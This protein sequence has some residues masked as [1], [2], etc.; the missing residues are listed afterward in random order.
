MIFS[1][2]VEQVNSFNRNGFVVFGG[3]VFLALFLKLKFNSRIIKTSGM[4]FV[5]TGVVFVALFCSVNLWNKD[6]AQNDLAYSNAV[7]NENSVLDLSKLL[8]LNSP[9][10]GLIINGVGIPINNS[11]ISSRNIK[12]ESIKN[13][14]IASG[15]VNSRTI[16]NGSIDAKDFDTKVSG[17]FLKNSN[18]GL[19]WDRLGLSDISIPTIGNPTVMDEL[20]DAFD[21]MWSAGVLSGGDI[22]NN[23]DGSISISSGE[24]MLRTSASDTAPLKSLAFPARNNI[25]LVN[26][27]TNYLFASYNGGNPIVETSTVITDFNCLDKCHLYTVVREGTELSI[28]DG[29]KQ[30]VDA[31][32]KLRRKNYETNPFAH[33]AGGTVLGNVGRHLTVSAGAFY[34]SL[35][36]MAHNAF[37]T[38]LA[39]TLDDRVFEAYYRNGSGGWTEVSDIKELDNLHYDDGSGTLATLDEG[40]Y[41]VF[42]VYIVMGQNPRIAVVYGRENNSD[43]DSAKAIATPQDVPPSISGA[44]AL[45]GRIIFQKNGDSGSPDLVESAFSNTFANGGNHDHG[46]MNGLDHDDHLQYALLDGRV[47]GQAMIGGSAANDALSIQGTSASGNIATN[48]SLIFKVGDAGVTTAMTILNNGNVGIGATDPGAYSLYINGTGFLNDAG[49]TYASDR[50]LKENIAPLE[51]SLSV[52]ERLNPVSFDYITGRKNQ[53]GFIAQEVQAVLPGLVEKR[54]DE[55]LGLR[56]DSLLPIAIQAIQE[57]QVEIEALQDRLGENPAQKI[58]ENKSGTETISAGKEFVAVENT[59]IGKDSKI[60]ITFEN[61]PE[62]YSWTEKETNDN[63]GYIGFKIIIANEAK[64]DLQVNWRI[65]D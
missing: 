24:A 10:G 64:K 16:K 39:G 54:P 8:E 22:T 28:L 5:L 30:N 23:G 37:N 13:K 31:N 55:M 41:G 33:V 51:N 56:T 38:S 47:G 35:E 32:R 60:F 44:G 40:V 58:I 42:W 7:E 21:F 53:F 65:E 17:G 57:Q 48:P 14:D 3:I 62:A 46:S 9:A 15:A 2:I 50:R 61:N 36:K 18:G 1:T 19:R 25:A 45:I 59:A 20:G 34:Y 26:N 63:G 6:K 12:N 43:I 11:V 49:W 52:I 29:R 27:T 4:F